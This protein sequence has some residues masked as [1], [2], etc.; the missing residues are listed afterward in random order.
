MSAVRPS[1][2]RRIRRGVVHGCALGRHCRPLRR[3]QHQHLR[4]TR[5]RGDAPVPCPLRARATSPR[6]TTMLPPAET[7]VT[8]K[9]AKPMSKH[10]ASSRVYQS[11]KRS[12]CAAHVPMVHAAH[13]YVGIYPHRLTSLAQRCSM[14]EPRALARIKA[15]THPG[16]GNQAAHRLGNRRPMFRAC[17]SSRPSRSCAGPDRPHAPARCVS[18]RR[19]RAAGFATA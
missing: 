1:R 12:S 8:T 3:N 14:R 7:G 2:A 19:W 15:P 10:D 18:H 9:R 5:E 17:V 4:R 16:S 13:A 11:E 6:N